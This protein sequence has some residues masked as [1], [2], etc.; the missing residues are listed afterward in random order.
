[1]EA[2]ITIGPEGAVAD[3]PPLPHALGAVARASPAAAQT[4]R[5]GTFIEGY[6]RLAW[7]RCLDHPLVIARDTV[8]LSHLVGWWNLPPG[9]RPGQAF[10]AGRQHVLGRPPAARTRS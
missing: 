3:P 1:M 4:V 10:P 2:P 5:P 8:L 9:E 6:L 7:R